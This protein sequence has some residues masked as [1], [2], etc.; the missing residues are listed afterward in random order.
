MCWLKY[1]Y[2]LCRGSKVKLF[3]PLANTRDIRTQSNKCLH[4]V[5]PVFSYCAVLGGNKLVFLS[6]EATFSTNF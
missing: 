6:V 3:F 4:C 5:L 2:R 1:T